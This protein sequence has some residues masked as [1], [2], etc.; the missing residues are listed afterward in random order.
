MK[1]TVVVITPTQLKTANLIFAEHEHL[2][3]K[4]PLLETKI[5]NLETINLNLVKIDSLRYTQI[6]LYE[7]TII[8]KNL[9]IQKMENQAKFKKWLLGSSVLTSIILAITCG[10]LA[11]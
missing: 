1:D 9:Q 2:I 4:V 11:K 3:S 10:L 6:S 7:E 5:S 8:A